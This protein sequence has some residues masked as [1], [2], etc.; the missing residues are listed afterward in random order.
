[1]IELQPIKDSPEDFEPIETRL[2]SFF[3]KEIYIPLIEELGTK[4]LLKNS[5]DDLIDA[6]QS[7]RIHFYRGAFDGQFNS[8]VS[9]EL[10]RQG[11]KFI[12]GQ[13]RISASQLSDETR[14]AIDQSESRFTRMIERIDRKIQQILPDEIAG[15]IQL[16]DLFSKVIW[17]TDQKFQSSIKGITVSPQLTEHKR[18]KIA[19]EWTNNMRLYIRDWTEKEIVKLR[20]DIQEKVFAGNR[21]GSMVKIIQQSYGSSQNKAKFLARQETNLLMAKFKEARYSDSG[22]QLYKWQTVI[23]SP[24]HPVRPRHKELNGKIFRFDDPPVMEDGQKKNPGED[25]GCRCVAIPVIRK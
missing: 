21:Y 10:K 11:A 20:K 2:I 19:D 7:G 24:K 5:D 23:G 8:R 14:H 13:W 3:R 16:Q 9:K 4:K 15:K 1:M 22:I 12:K 17:K 6:I 18:A 25:Y